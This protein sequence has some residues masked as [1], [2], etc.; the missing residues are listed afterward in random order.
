M[1]SIFHWNINGLRGNIDML[2]QYL[3]V[4]KPDVICLNETK[5]NDN[6]LPNINGY[7]LVS[8]QD[9]TSSVKGGVA[10]LCKENLDMSEI[11]VDIKD[12][13]AASIKI[14]RKKVVIISSYW[15]FT[16]EVMNID[17]LDSLIG[18]FDQCVLVGDFNARNTIWKANRTCRRG[19]LLEGLMDKRDLFILNDI[20]QPTMY[21]LHWQT[22]SLIDLALCSA[23]TSHMIQSCS[24]L[25]PVSGDTMFHVP[26]LLRL[27]KSNVFV[28]HPPKEVYNIQ[29]CDWAMYKSIL[30]DKVIP[31]RNA[32]KPDPKNLDTIAELSGH[33]LREAFEQCCPKREV[34]PQ[35]TRV[36]PAT[37]ALIKDR[38]RTNRLIKA[39]P[40]IQELKTL[41]NKQTKELKRTIKKEKEENYVRSTAQLN[42]R[43]QKKYWDTI[44][45]L[46]SN[47]TAKTAAPTLQCNDGTLSSDPKKVADTFA[48][49]LGK[50]HRVHS[51]ANFDS[52]FRRETDNWVKANNWM[53]EPRSNT[54]QEEEGDTSEMLRPLTLQEL[55]SKLRRSKKKSSPGEDKVSYT[56]INQA[57]DSFKE[58]LVYLFESCL[59]TG[60]FPTTWKCATGVMLPK[61]GKDAK[62]P[63][64][65]RPIS[66]LSCLGKTLERV[67][68][69]RLL[70]FL[71]DAKVINDW[72]RAYLKKKEG[73]EH[74]Y[75]L[76]NQL[77][78][79]QLKKWTSALL[80]LDVEKAFDSVWQNGLRLKLHRL[81]IPVKILRLLSSF[82]TNRTIKVRVNGILSDVVKLMAGT[83]Q[84]SVLSPILFIIYVN[85]LPVLPTSHLSQFADDMG[86][87]VHDKN[88]NRVRI[89]IQKQIDELEKWCNKWHIKLNA[90]KTQLLVITSKKVEIEVKIYGITVKQCT[91]ATLLGTTIDKQLNMASHISNLY[92]K[93]HR[94]LGMLKCLKG[95]GASPDVLKHTY[96]TF[97]RPVLENGYHFNLLTSNNVLS[98]LQKLQNM[99][100]RT[101]LRCSNY[102]NVKDMHQALE[103]PMI[104]DHFQHLQTKAINRYGESELILEMNEKLLSMV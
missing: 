102:A 28:K 92:E 7:I 1:G 65:Y 50:I 59:K 5:M 100:F 93:G 68:A 44:K 10:I 52:D 94:R 42:L 32:L 4:I 2:N 17:K 99:A 89:R 53:F 29:K 87:Y 98:K 11:A 26:I 13:C 41:F 34:V 49:N 25:D 69:D 30:N 91:E 12:T 37:L 60:Y 74:L 15:G 75:K 43:D 27:K 104:R 81:G 71:E 103:L 9:H 22:S 19:A 97:I 67:I 8:R 36:S 101:I 82:L 83:P 66:L 35:L 96:L 54:N 90:T 77:K 64:N 73:S 84:G 14:G 47:S 80:L 23:N 61:N 55:Q 62:I 57:P 85:D 48:T 72:Q 31:M 63:N 39:N 79:A 45:K 76:S 95:W 70:E 86:Y 46:T 56:I 40:G 6:P 88:H 21:S 58:F 24:T 78:Q 38:R 20:N 16:G 51:D 18:K 3:G 33:V